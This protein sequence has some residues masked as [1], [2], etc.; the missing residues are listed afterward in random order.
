MELKDHLNPA[1]C[2]Y[3]SY[4]NG[5][6]QTESI[7]IALE[8]AID[9]CH[10]LGQDHVLLDYQSRTSYPAAVEHII[11]ATELANL[12]RK[13]LATDGNPI[14]FA[15]FTRKNLITRNFQ[16]GLDI[17]RLE[18]I[19]LINTDDEAEILVWLND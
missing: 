1:K 17:A 5:N 3:C 2:V 19:D 8:S 7:I 14:K 18:D 10:R 4:E 15:L 12:Y 11:V 6:T 13:H 9:E 16:P